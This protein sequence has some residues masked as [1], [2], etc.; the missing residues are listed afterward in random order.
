M[1]IMREPDLS[2]IVHRPSSSGGDF[3][4]RVW[5]FVR[6]VPAGRVV[7]YGQVAAHLGAPFAARAV[8]SVLHTT[9]RSAEVPCQRVV[10]RW[11]R[12]APTYGDGGFE[13]HRMELLADGVEVRPDYTVDLDVY[14][15]NPPL[16][17]IED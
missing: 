16:S 5:A 14:R 12:L 6:S 17:G 15:W 10:N 4:H 3:R 8:G 13:Q 11:G 7:T 2:S 1:H 9:P